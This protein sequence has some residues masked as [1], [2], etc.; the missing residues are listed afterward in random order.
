MSAAFVI[1]VDAREAS[2]VRRDSIETGVC[3]RC[4]RSPNRENRKRLIRPMVDM[5]AGEVAAAWPCFYPGYARHS[6]GA[7]L[8]QRDLSE[9]RKERAC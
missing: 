3:V 1:E 9:L 4:G 5:T 8:V 7:A 6:A 2:A